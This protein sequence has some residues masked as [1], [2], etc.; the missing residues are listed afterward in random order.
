MVGSEPS[1]IYVPDNYS[2]IQAA[3]IA[4]EEGDTIIVRPDTYHEDITISK[5][6]T[7]IGEDKSTTIINSLGA[8]EAVSITAHDVVF[9]NFTVMNASNCIRLH[10]TNRVTLSEIIISNYTYNGFECTGS[11]SLT[12]INCTALGGNDGN[13]GFRLAYLCGARLLNCKSSNH[14]NDGFDIW[15]SDCVILVNCSSHYNYRG[16]YL[17]DANT[18]SVCG[19]EAIGNDDGF[20]IVYA[21]R[22]Y[23]SKCR[24]HNNT[25]GFDLGWSNGVVVNTN[26]TL[27]TDDGID[28]YESYFVFR[29]CS[30]L[31]N[32]DHEIEL[33]LGS[34]DCRWCWWGS[35]TGP[36][37][38]IGGNVQ[39]DP[40]QTEFNQFEG[41]ICDLRCEL[42]C[43][44]W[45]V[46]Y[47]DQITPKP[48]G[49]GAALTSD[50]LASAFVTTKLENI[51]EGLDTDNDFVNQATGE[52][53]G[54]PGT[55]I[56]TFGGPFVNPIVKR[57]ENHSTSTS[58][59]APVRF[60][61]ES[62]TFYFQYSNGTNIPNASLP[63]S[64]INN[65]E[66]LFVIE[67]YI[68]GD[69]RLI[70]ICY[71]FGWPG[72]YAAGKYFDKEVFPNLGRYTNSWIIV[73]WEDTNG[74]GF[75]NNPGEGDTYTLIATGN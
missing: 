57:A 17:S 12:I 46:T 19:S 4:A 65:D 56:L 21:E 59:R 58:H 60:H 42:K 32:L 67:R 70:T 24:V 29:Y 2:N 27:N 30:M 28:T 40:W 1:V 16:F 10:G 20:Y 61:S 72:T 15:N 73:H 63:L 52:P 75:V 22:F 69:G 49:C 44:E 37:V 31:D 38:V 18:V 47:P 34:L 64:V 25:D 36:A 5:S 33:F 48:L 43:L 51:A 11:N 68:D 23:A 66:D 45:R 71:G 55:S 9:S 6:L 3:I 14:T 41:L 8:Y 13:D 26:I 50:W 53:V 39:I 7:L 35:P 62:D 74:D 54:D